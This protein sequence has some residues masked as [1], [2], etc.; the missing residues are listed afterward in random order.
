MVKNQ[1][2]FKTFRKDNANNEAGI[3]ENKAGVRTIVFE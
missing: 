2:R 1:R 3:E